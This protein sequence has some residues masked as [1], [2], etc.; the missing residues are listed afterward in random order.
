M[1]SD[2][3]YSNSPPNHVPCCPLP[4]K[5]CRKTTCT[6]PVNFSEYII[7]TWIILPCNHYFHS[8]ARP[9]TLLSSIHLKQGPLNCVV[10]RAALLNPTLSTAALFC[11]KDPNWPQHS[12]WMKRLI[13]F[14]SF[15]ISS[16]LRGGGGD[17]DYTL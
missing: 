10:D 7:N 11:R 3:L 1:I 14:F 9:R 16:V 5:R 6:Y 4:P 8:G 2:Q 13:S 12:K 17:W 15:Y